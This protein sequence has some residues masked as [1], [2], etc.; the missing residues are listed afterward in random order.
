MADKFVGDSVLVKTHTADMDIPA[1]RFVK[2]VTATGSQPHC[3]LS[4]SAETAAGVARNAYKSGQLVDVVLIG[5]AFVT[6]AGNVA[7]GKAVVSDA[8]GKAIEGGAPGLG[9]AQTD[10]NSGD[11]VLVLLGVG[12]A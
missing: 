9:Q 3:T 11:P 1:M 10:A 7:A 5:T 2:L 4:G 6:T 12:G 8:T